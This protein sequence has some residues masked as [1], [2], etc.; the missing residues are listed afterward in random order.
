MLL[1]ECPCLVLIY[2]SYGLFDV[3]HLP[4][5]LFAV[6][7]A[8]VP[9]RLPETWYLWCGWLCLHARMR[10]RHP[11]SLGKADVVHIWMLGGLSQAPS[12]LSSQCFCTLKLGCAFTAILSGASAVGDEE[13]SESFLDPG[14][15]IL[16]LESCCLRLSNWNG[17]RHT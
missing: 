5:T 4:V 16:P 1:K 12:L 2:S 11:C 17:D 13:G 7:E 14:G 6:K 8:V 10:Y 9:P 3:I 15:V